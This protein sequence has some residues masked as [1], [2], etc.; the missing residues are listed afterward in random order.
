MKHQ[1]RDTDRA[2]V[3][4]SHGI[5]T[6]EDACDKKQRFVALNDA[7]HAAKSVFQR[8]GRTATTYKCSFCDGW[9]VTKLKHLEE[10]A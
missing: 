1:H 5:I 9:H 10:S 3:L 4:V 7:R 2:D 6:R 8:T